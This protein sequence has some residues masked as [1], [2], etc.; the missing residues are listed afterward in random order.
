MRQAGLN[1]FLW[2]AFATLV[3]IGAYIVLNACDF[4]LHPLFGSGACQAPAANAALESERAKEAQL[5]S[6]IHTAEIHLALLPACPRPL[7]PPPRPLPVKVPDPLPAVDPKIEQTLEVPKKIEDLKGCWQSARGDIDI[8]SDDAEH[9]VVGK[10]RLCYCFRGNGQGV[11][12]I[13]YS[14]GDACRSRLVARISPEQLS[15][16]HDV[17]SC[18]KHGDYVVHDIT[19]GNDQTDKTLCEIISRGKTYIRR[20]E[21]FVR[22]TNEY[23]NWDG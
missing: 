18:R 11:A 2:S 17:I 8:L 22:V 6:R 21:Q 12:Q 4:G 13:F 23:C 5:Q 3:L 20:L 10:A 14:D 7:P 16:R 9:K 15:M 19:C 1:V